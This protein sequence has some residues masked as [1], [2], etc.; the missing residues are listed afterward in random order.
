MDAMTETPA[1]TAPPVGLRE[2]R[3][4]RTRERIVAEALRLFAEHGYAATTCEQI[5]AAAEVSPATFYRYFPGK[6]EVVLQDDYDPLLIAALEGRP[7]GEHPVDA[8]RN[9]VRG[10]LATTNQEEREV[11][12]ERARLILG[13]PALRARMYEQDETS[14]PLIS[15]ALAARMGHPVDDVRVQVLAAAIFAALRVGIERWAD[16]GGDLGEAL[17]TALA[18][19]R[20]AAGG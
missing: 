19:L 20:E 11:I 17:G 14:V 15:P 2:L 6:D 12:R 5:A 13:T 1:G 7:A 3:K 16:E 9:A 10:A 8:V 4:R 18:A